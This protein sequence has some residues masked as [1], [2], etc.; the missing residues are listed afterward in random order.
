MAQGPSEVE[1]GTVRTAATSTA[2]TAEALT[3]DDIR[4]QIEH[5]RAE[6]RCSSSLD[7]A[8]GDERRFRL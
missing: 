1:E 8:V 3:T 6:M 4:S 2:A 7:C 5:T